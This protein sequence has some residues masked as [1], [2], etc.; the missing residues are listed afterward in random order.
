MPEALSFRFSTCFLAE[1]D[2]V[3]SLIYKKGVTFRRP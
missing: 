3:A 1:K 2:Q